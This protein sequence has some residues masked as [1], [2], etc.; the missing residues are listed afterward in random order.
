MTPPAGA[1][2]EITPAL[3]DDFAALTGDR[4]PIH[5]E[6][7][8]ARI[9]RFRERIA[10]GMLPVLFFAAQAAGGRP[11]R[12]LK[13]RF[14]APIRLGE[15]VALDS[16]GAEDGAGISF[17]IVTAAGEA[18]TSGRIVFGPASVGQPH[19]ARAGDAPS[20]ELNDLTAD[21]VEVGKSETIRFRAGTGKLRVLTAQPHPSLVAL[22]FSS[23]L[24][25]M[26]L[27]GRHATFMDL[28][29]S[30]EGEF[31]EGV[32]YAL[33]GTVEQYLPGSGKASL[34]LRW[35]G[36]AGTVASGKANVMVSNPPPSG[37]SCA[38]LKE[39]LPA[40]RLDGRVALVTGASR[41]I[42]EAT[43]KLLAML[44]AHVVVHFNQGRQ[45][46]EAIVEDIR[47]NGGKALVA[48][49][50]LATAAGVDAL[51]RA[52]ADSAGGVDILV[53]NAVRDFAPRPFEATSRADL[54]GELDVS[55]LGMHECCRGALPHMRRQ[56]W[57]KI[58]NIGTVATELPVRSQIKYI[59]AKSAVVGY[60]RSLAV[61]VAADNVQVNMVV[62]AMTDTSLIASLPRAMLDRLVADT[63]SGRLLRP[64]EVA[65]AIAFLCSD[66]A[67][68]I[69]GQKLVLN[70]G[71]PPFI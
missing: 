3:L 32:E 58:V 27:P 50:D 56:Q 43:A 5:M 65:R 41:G 25:G 70:Q 60:T 7:E 69:S 55:L 46:A 26:R 2:L 68:C 61:E 45:A 64:M 57:G 17:R 71:E 40:L 66:W 15:T 18:A 20:Y 37:I 22:A 13:A 33:S 8:F 67:S 30:C 19:P 12:A 39:S 47:A 51:F 62:P 11:V 48:G 31:E 24:V 14:L 21:Q 34:S 38:Q 28:D 49:A 23:T 16:D 1:R 54:L 35:D 42:G 9:T 44:G 52:I 4:S 10:H 36:P 63:S 29:V 59:A 53:N 6:P